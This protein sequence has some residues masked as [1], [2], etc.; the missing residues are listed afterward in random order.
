[1]PPSIKPSVAGDITR[2]TTVKF[3]IENPPQNFRVTKWEFWE[4]LS[5][6]KTESKVIRKR[7]KRNRKTWNTSWEG[8]IVSSGYLDVE[9]GTRTKVNTR[10][11]K[12][13][14]GKALSHTI[15]VVPRTGNNWKTTIKI[16]NQDNLSTSTLTPSQLKGARKPRIPPQSPS[17]LGIH[18]SRTIPDTIDL[19]NIVVNI[20]SGLN[21]GYSFLNPIKFDFHSYGYI[22][23][24]LKTDQST[25][26]KAQDG[27][28][29][30]T[31]G[32]GNNK[33]FHDAKSGTYTVIRGEAVRKNNFLKQNN[34]PVY[35]YKPGSKPKEIDRKYW[36]YNASEDKIQIVKAL[37][38]QFLKVYAI[39]PGSKPKIRPAATMYKYPRM[40]HADLLKY[41]QRHEYAGKKHSHRA[42]L[43]KANK[44]LDP[45]A[46]AESLISRPKKRLNLRRLFSNRLKLVQL[47]GRTHNLVH[48]QSTKREGNL[49]FEGT[50]DMHDINEDD[51]G[52]EVGKIWDPNK[53]KFF[54]K[55]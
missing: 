25:F 2:G 33:T 32:T 8:I 1:L 36:N 48:E 39:K 49:K 34:I 12:L 16:K 9:W 17:D 24:H 31:K 22:N 35:Y 27:K 21:R 10:R 18:Q 30:F 47:A 51:N 42:N 41:T 5:D 4:I 26:S 45:R 40:K 43:I 13:T 6:G 53:K 15:K 46:Y 28:V 54:P 50:V 14:K 29:Y 7:Q 20:R 3:T 37:E 11:Y 19:T 55:R 38:K 23:D 44:A 52:V